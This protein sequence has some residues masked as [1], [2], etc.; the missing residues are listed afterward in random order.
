MRETSWP[1]PSEGQERTRFKN[2]FE[3]DLMQTTDK[4]GKETMKSGFE[5]H[6]LNTMTIEKDVEVNATDD[7]NN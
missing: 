7:A 1:R 5:V 4:L 3:T 2:T 6:E